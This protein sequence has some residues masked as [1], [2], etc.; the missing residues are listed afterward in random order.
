MCKYAIVIV[1]QV[2]GA[3]LVAG[4]CLGVYSLLRKPPNCGMGLNFRITTHP[5]FV[6][7]FNNDSFVI[8]ESTTS[9]LKR[10]LEF[11]DESGWGIRKI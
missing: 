10:R 1:N 7:K 2:L 5:T 4:N 3:S 11:I 6:D 8:I 9:K